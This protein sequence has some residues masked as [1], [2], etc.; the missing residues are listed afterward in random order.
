M[1]PLRHIHILLS[2]AILCCTCF[3][4]QSIGPASRDIADFAFELTISNAAKRAEMLAAHPEHVTIA[5][6]R[7]LIAL[8]NLRFTGADYAKALDI[9]QFAEKISAQIGDKEGVATARLNIGSVYYFQGNY[10]LALDHYRKAETL[11]LSLNNCFEAARCHFGIGLTYQARRK[12]ADALKTYEEALK[13]FQ[14]AGDR[15]EILN[16]LASIGGLQYELGNYEAASKT[17]LAVA[18]MGENGEIFSRVAET[19]YMQ[20]D[21]T[22]A[23]I[24]YQRALDLFTSQN[25]LAG[26]ISALGGAGNCYFYQ[27]NYDRALELYNR[28]LALEQ[29]LNDQIGIATRLQN[30]GHVHRARGDYAS[31]LEPYFKSLSIAEQQQP[32]KATAATTLGSIG[33]VRAMQGDNAQAVDYFNRSLNAYQTGGDEIG[34]SRMLSY[35]G[36]ARY[37]QGE[38]DLA[39]EAYQKSLELHQKRS[40]HLNRAHVLLGIGSVY[41]AQQKYPLALQSFHDA[42]ALY[43]AL[44]RKADMAD[45]LSRLAFTYRKQGDNARALE[46]AQTAARTAKDAEVLGIAAYALTEVGNAQ[47]ALSRR[48]EALTAFAEAITVQRSIRPETGPDGLETE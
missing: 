42:L 44:A 48:N 15:T 22:Q 43:T 6:R 13:E 7:E 34:M 36:N 10:E 41:S 17:L 20:H 27:R 14:L 46:F 30:I 39:L 32:A 3:G 23:L 25:S 11:F 9:Y 37:T 18:G 26:I 16:T 1:R 33:L 29:K 45:A 40:D 19:F 31:A 47:R 24:Y 28:S 21:Y 35:I 12:K 2:I 5:L 38:Y 4:Q 8:G